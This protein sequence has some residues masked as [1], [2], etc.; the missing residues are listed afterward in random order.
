[1]LQVEGHQWQAAVAGTDHLKG[2][3]LFQALTQ[4]QQAQQAG[5][6]ILNRNRLW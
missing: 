2:T 4:L 6:Q 1:V 3:Q 5:R